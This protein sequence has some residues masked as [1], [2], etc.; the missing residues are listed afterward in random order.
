MTYHCARCLAPVEIAATGPVCGKHGPVDQ[1]F[2][3]SG[4]GPVSWETLQR[5]VQAAVECR[6][7]HR[8]FVPRKP[9][10]RYCW[11]CFNRRAACS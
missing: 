4:E 5:S 10:Y 8:S 11:T 6:S 9:G 7:C 2:L 1:V 3:R